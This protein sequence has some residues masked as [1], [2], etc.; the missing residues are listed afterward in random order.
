MQTHKHILLALLSFVFSLH[1]FAQKE[2]QILYKGNQAYHSGKLVEAGNHYRQSLQT[3]PDYYKANFNLGDALYRTANMMKAGKIPVPDKKMTVDSAA[4]LV[5]NQAADQFEV[6]AESTTNADTAQKA[7]HN[8]G[9]SKLMQK[10]FEA[11]ISGYKK[12]LRLNPKDEDTRYNL[13]F[14][15]R[16]LA[17]QQKDKKD[18]DDKE[19]KDKDKNEKKEQNKKDKED[20]NNQ[21]DKDKQEAQ[22]PQM[23][24][25]QAEKMLNALKNDEK[26]KQAERKIKGE[27]GQ[28]VKVEKDW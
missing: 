21:N 17:K 20:I 25:E 22:Q 4:A 11:A 27:P 10:D 23:S 24:K 12:A 3:K 1:G 15:Q 9:N 5:Y 13:A 26:K 2:K 6:A 7:W 8:Y 19:N 14:A 18:K 28:R 16:E